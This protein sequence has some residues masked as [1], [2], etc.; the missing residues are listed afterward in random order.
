MPELLPYHFSEDLIQ[1]IL[2]GFDNIIDAPLKSKIHKKAKREFG[3]LVKKASG[4]DTHVYTSVRRGYETDKGKTSGS[5]VHRDLPMGIKYLM[6]VANN[7]RCSTLYIPNWVERP[8]EEI[9]SED[10]FALNHA[11]ELEFVGFKKIGFN[12]DF[13]QAANGQLSRFVMEHEFHVAPPL[14]AGD[15]KLLLWAVP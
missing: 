3:K 5:D 10:L 9:C 4:T 1:E 11:D 13:I 8:R 14:Y 7:N 6:T 2:D 15:L 12:L